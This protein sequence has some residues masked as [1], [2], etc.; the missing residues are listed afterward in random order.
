ME[1]LRARF[2]DV[3]RELLRRS[4]TIKTSHL[5]ALVN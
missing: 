1:D 4:H 5:A 2:R 3:V